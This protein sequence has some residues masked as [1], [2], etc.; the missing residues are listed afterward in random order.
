MS[1]NR[2]KYVL[3]IFAILIM[4]HHLGQ[5]TSAFWVPDSVR[6]H[7]LEPFV[8][9][10]YLLVSFFFFCS[11][12]G[13]RKSMKEKSDYF[14]GFLKR[15][16]NR[17]L[18]IFVIT[19]IIWLVVRF[20]FGNV[21]TPFNPYNW[22][23]YSIVVL[24]FGFF[25]SYRKEKKFSLILMAVWILI[26]SLICYLL[27]KGNW[28]YNSTPVFLAGIIAADRELKAPQPDVTP[29]DTPLKK[30]LIKIIIP[31]VILIITFL[32]SENIDKL[33][34]FAGIPYYGLF[35]FISV[36]LQIAAGTA[37]SLILYILLKG[38]DTGESGA[39]KILSF[40]GSMTLE[41]YLIHGLFVQIFG[42]HFI[43]DKTPPVFYIKNVFV[44]VLVVFILSSASAFI[45]KKAG[46]IIIA[47]YERSQMFRKI[48]N[49]QKKIVCVLLGIFVVITVIYS[50]HRHNMSNDVEP[51]LEKYK[52]ENIQTVNVN[53]T[54]VALYTAGEGDYTVVLLGSHSDPCPTLY[55]RPLANNLTD[56]YKVVIIDYPGKGYSSDSDMERTTDFYAEIIHGT[57]ADLGITKNVILVPNELSAIYSYRY[58]EKYP[59]EVAGLVGIDAVMPVLATRFLDGNYN[60][61]DE[62][63]WYLKRIAF[64]EKMNQ[65]M[66][67]L[68]GYISFQTPMFDYVFYGS[69]MKEYYPVMEEM[70]IRKFMQ[71][72]MLSEKQNAYDNCM[73][74]E[75]Y[76]LPEELPVS[77][78]L[79]DSIKQTNYYGLNWSNEYKKMM[80]NEDIQSVTIIAG[81]AY[82][83]YYNPGILAKK[84]D[85]L[86]SVIEQ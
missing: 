33:Y 28:W 79:N 14:K 66:L 52:N 17:I 81:N 61:V 26:Y 37:F 23:V 65:N 30:K 72:A 78:L 42:H 38:K 54:E 10:G 60:S 1:K 40:F 22:Y 41:F 8:P 18:M 63:K 74:M 16:L 55:L 76:K 80:T 82:V 11:G 19:E 36:I 35:N 7:G 71:D 25:F 73:L 70:Y 75:N 46:D 85:E 13:L 45:L 86:A 15:R 83:I 59:D 69:G 84:I 21:S 64:L 12:Y 34:R 27:I 62:Y 24:Y 20:V 4:L 9:I 6:Q 39:L 43:D 47:F 31:A 32:I 51:K 67:K 5:K 50:V 49:D 77:F 29:P 44:Y 53:G 48:F 57:L 68:T 58:I 2:S 3:G 56:T